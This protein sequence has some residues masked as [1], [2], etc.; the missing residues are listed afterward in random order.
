MLSLGVSQLI[1]WGVS[2]YLVGGFGALIEADLGWSPALVQGGFSAALLMM[3]VSSP[4]VGRLMDRH[5]GRRVMSAGSVLMALGCAGLAAAHS[6]ATYYAA[7]LCLGLA[8]RLSLY[9]AA[10]AA[11]ARI[12]GPGARSAMSQITLLGGLASTVFWP[13]GAL[14]ADAFGW[15]GALA[16]YAGIAL[17]TLPLH[18]SLPRGRHVEAGGGGAR[19][20][21]APL[22]GTRG[23]RFLAGL[24]YVAIVTLTNFLNTGMSADMIAILAGLGMASAATVWIAGLRGVGQSAARL[25][26]VLF[27]RRLHPCHLNLLACAALPLCFA[28]G[29]FSGRSVLAALGFALLY[30]AGNGLVTITRG[31][32]PLVLF[33]PRIYGS[34]VGQLITPGFLLSAAAPLA[35]VFVITRWGDLVALDLSVLLAGL[36][37]LA[38]LVLALRFAGRGR[39]AP[40]STG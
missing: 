11:L 24:L 32:L 7:W 37:F 39:H 26:E 23:E 33:D 25:A 15:R 30:G 31:T 27:G 21:E 35:Y 6:V 9:D 38:A 19:S 28:I 34:L 18:L 36:A 29:L 8:M 12:G 17:A 4:L 2:Y 22:A 14:L 10:F 13:L 5:G 3:G 40:R 1:C 16:A 20:A